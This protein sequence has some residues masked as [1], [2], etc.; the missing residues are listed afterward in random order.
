M[1]T[2][3]DAVRQ[4]LLSHADALWLDGS[5]V[6]SAEIPEDLREAGRQ[7]AWSGSAIDPLSVAV[8]LAT[9]GYPEAARQLLG[10]HEVCEQA[11]KRLGPDRTRRFHEL[12][13]HLAAASG[14]AE[15]ASVHAAR[16]LDTWVFPPEVL[17]AAS[18]LAR[19][20]ANS[21]YAI[22]G[23]LLE[24][25]GA[26]SSALNFFLHMVRPVACVTEPEPDLAT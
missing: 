6:L 14:E 18:I 17:R 25:L 12:W 7:L 21:D 4:F 20:D 24:S 15:L 16:L 5:L 8:T 10:E 22:I 19:Q 1:E 13:L 2:P 11:V 3:E 26:D 23:T 9:S